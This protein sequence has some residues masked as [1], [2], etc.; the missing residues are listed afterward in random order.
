MPLPIAISLHLLLPLPLPLPW[1]LTWALTWTLTW[2][3]TLLLP[4]PLPLPLPQSPAFLCVVREMCF[5]WYDWGVTG[6]PVA[7]GD[8][9]QGEVR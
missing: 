9:L 7:T 8:L 1:T 6:S 3:L 2:T 5:K 4:L